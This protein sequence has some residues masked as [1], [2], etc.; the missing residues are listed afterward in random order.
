LFLGPDVDRIGGWAIGLQA[1]RESRRHPHGKDT[2]M[3]AQCNTSQDGIEPKKYTL[4]SEF[5]FECHKGMKCYT[6][7]CS[8]I[9][10]ILTPYDIVRMKNRLGL[11]CDQFLA[12]YTKPEMLS[13]TKLPV[14]I[15]KMLDD[16][17]ESC[18]FVTPEGCAIYEDRP[19][20]CRY[21]PLGAAAFREQEIQPT[22]EDFY[23][24]VREAHCLGFESDKKWTVAEWRKNQ[25]VEPYDEINRGWLEI[26][27]RKKSFGFQAELSE[28]SRGMFFMVS[29]NVDRL[30]RFIFESTFLDKFEIDEKT[31][32]EIKTDEVARIKFGFDWLKTALF[33]ADGFEMKPEATKAYMEKAERETKEARKAAPEETG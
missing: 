6:S 24:M 14:I 28:Q 13:R 10:N 26:M 2:N 15:M 1:N 22:G 33:G 30:K 9:T 12:I 18:P 32:E 11:S 4:D 16:E 25:G 23:F 8:G 20:S 29:S 27:L 3:T 31:L 21:Y 17:K 19:L 7:C 5:T